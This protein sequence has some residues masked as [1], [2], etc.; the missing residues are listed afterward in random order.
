MQRITLECLRVQASVGVLEH[1]LKSRQPLVIT[2]TVELT[3]RPL[4]PPADTVDHV[5][6]YRQLREVALQESQ[7]GHV[8]MLETLGGRIA[9][10]L[11]EQPQIERGS[12]RI[13]KPSVFPDCDGAA[14]EIGFDRS[15]R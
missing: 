9:A 8:N 15:T 7:R 3:E 5:F 6:D 11:L 10:R 4:I 1:E 13:L 2:I 12:V 14:V